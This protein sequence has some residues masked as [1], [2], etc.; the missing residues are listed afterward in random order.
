MFV[1]IDSF[2]TNHPAVQANKDAWSSVENEALSVLRKMKDSPEFNDPN[3]DP[4]K[5]A[6]VGQRINP[7]VAFAPIDPVFGE[8]TEMQPEGLSLADAWLIRAAGVTKEE[9]HA[10]TSHG[11]KLTKGPPGDDLMSGLIS[12]HELQLLEEKDFDVQPMRKLMTL[13]YS[14]IFTE[15]PPEITTADDELNRLDKLGFDIQPLK[16]LLDQGFELVHGEEEMMIDERML[17]NPALVDQLI[18]DGFSLKSSSSDSPPVY[19]PELS[20]SGI[21]SHL[22]LPNIAPP[23]GDPLIDVSQ[24]EELEESIQPSLE[25]RS[26]TG[27]AD[28]VIEA[29]QNERV[30]L[31]AQ[32][33]RNAPPTRNIAEARSRFYHIRPPT[34]AG[35][36]GEVRDVIGF[37]LP[38][39]SVSCLMPC[40]HRSLLYLASVL[41]QTVD[42]R[43]DHP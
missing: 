3:F 7:G 16:N 28:S 40:H 1:L 34:P 14:I 37:Q 23:S 15:I 27:R 42:L 39:V 8:L 9:L 18:T 20:L 30:I 5:L 33:A 4:T 29:L 13:G 10:M 43:I 35:G 6:K 25:S 12:D 26:Y 19:L 17:L 11:F 32:Q 31:D 24:Q 22:P 2:L 21:N 38:R 41:T 36:K